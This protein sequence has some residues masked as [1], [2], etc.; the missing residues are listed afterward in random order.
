M[1]MKIHHA[2]SMLE[3][4]SPAHPKASYPESEMQMEGSQL[5]LGVKSKLLSY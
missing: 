4:Q 2:N 5:N 1:T 3:S